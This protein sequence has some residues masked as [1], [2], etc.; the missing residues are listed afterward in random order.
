MR[1]IARRAGVHFTTVSLALRNSPRLPRETCEHLQRVAAE[2]GYTPDPMLSSLAVYR[3]SLRPV[4]YHATLAWVTA[5]ASRDQW[6]E[7][8]VF[9]E[10]YQGAT[11]RAVELGF[12]LEHFWL[13]EPGMSSARATQILRTRGISGLIIA[14]LPKAGGTVQLDWAQFSSVAIGY[15]LVSP[16]LHLACAHQYRCIRLALHELA[17]RGY[18]RVGLVVLRSSDERVDHNWLAGY[19]IEQFEVPG[20]QRL[21]PLVLT[22]WDDGAFDAWLARELPDAIISKL[23]ETLHALRTRGFAV[24][25]DIGLAYLSD[26]H[27]GDEHSGVD[28]NS[29]KV[30]AAAVDFVVGMLHRNERGVP[31]FA[32]RL[33]IEGKWIEG[34]TVRPRPA[35]STAA[36]V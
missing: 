13:T 7:V 24:P 19:L 23:P 15:S 16:S 36:R 4:D 5:F 22:A 17:L 34:S 8:P 10:Q 1:D 31:E 30:G 3:N 35:A 14:P 2:M 28:E 20:K 29:G 33:L 12:R 11:D 27:P 18:R 25:R 32:H 9:R 21:A 6:R 26:T